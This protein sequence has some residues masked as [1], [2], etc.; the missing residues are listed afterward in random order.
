MNDINIRNIFDSVVSFLDQFEAR[1]FN[2]SNFRDE[3]DNLLV[4]IREL[5]NSI[6]DDTRALLEELERNIERLG[7]LYNEDHLFRPSTN[8][9]LF[10]HPPPLEQNQE[11]RRGRPRYHLSKD[12]LVSLREMGLSWSR[13]ASIYSISKWTV[14]RRAREYE[15]LGINRFNQIR[16]DDLMEIIGSYLNTQSRLVGFSLVYGYLE[17]I[18]VH[19]QQSRVRNILQQFDPTF[20]QMRWAAVI[21]RRTYNVRAPNS[22]WHLDG[23]HSLVRYGF[24]IHGCIDGFSRLITFLK[25][26]TNNNSLTVLQLFT[27]AVESYGSPSRVRTD[28][29]GENVRVWDFMEELMGLN[30]GSALRGTSTQ[31]QR[32]ERLWRDVF[33]CVCSTYYYIFQ[34]VTDSGFLN[35]DILLHK[36]V[37]HFIFLPRINNSLKLF[38]DAWNHHPL[39]TE[40]SRSPIRIWQ[41]GMAD[42]RNRSLNTTGSICGR[43]GTSDDWNVYGIDPNVF[44]PAP[45]DNSQVL[46]DNVLDDYPNLQNF[47]QS[48]INPLAESGNLGVDLFL[49]ALEICNNL[50]N[51]A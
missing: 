42:I 32:I 2:A 5:Y 16:D 39:R 19:V 45:E 29:G 18:G 23:H 36:I 4:D 48:N 40:R 43:D 24:V 47:L 21:H 10:D 12:T 22:L 31:N 11:I 26:S 37:L 20:S 7:V 49:N 27:D 6:D 46:V 14:L 38:T 34:A 13:I 44:P 15:I 50:I 3:V 9:H 30:R 17:S 1:Q 8:L 28:F 25:C 51:M 33:R 41:M 35:I